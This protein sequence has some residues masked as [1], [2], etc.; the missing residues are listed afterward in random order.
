M[1]IFT[2]ATVIAIVAMAVWFVLRVID[3]GLKHAERIERI[4]HGYPV[5]EKEYIDYTTRT[6]KEGN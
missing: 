4:K 2:A 5:D 1:G 3:M 6:Q